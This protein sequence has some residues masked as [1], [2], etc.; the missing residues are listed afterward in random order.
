M[1]LRRYVVILAHRI[2]EIK[3]KTE[4]TC[5]TECLQTLLQTRDIS[6][7]LLLNLQSLYTR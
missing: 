1:V 2:S 3:L 4:A 5:M 7:V 6:A